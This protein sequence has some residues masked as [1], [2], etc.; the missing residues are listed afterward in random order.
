MVLWDVPMALDEER[1]QKVTLV[2]RIVLIHYLL[3]S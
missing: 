1:R 3:I 2:L